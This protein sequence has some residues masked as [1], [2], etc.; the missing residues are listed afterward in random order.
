M[1]DPMRAIAIYISDVALYVEGCADK[2][3]IFEYDDNKKM[4]YNKE[5]NFGYPLEDIIFD[6]DWTIFSYDRVEFEENFKEE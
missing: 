1:K 6:S 3:H 5:H 4:F 2:I